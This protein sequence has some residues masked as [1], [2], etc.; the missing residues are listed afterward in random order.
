MENCFQSLTLK[1]TRKYPNVYRG[2]TVHS[3]LIVSDLTCPKI[4]F[5]IILRTKDVLGNDVNSTVCIII[6]SCKA[7][8]VAL[9][10][11]IIFTAHYSRRDLYLPRR[12]TNCIER[13]LRYDVYQETN[14]QPPQVSRTAH[15][16]GYFQLAQDP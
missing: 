5:C 14:S 7:S 12:V 15:I 1:K 13:T 2:L 8:G 9:A 11:N 3:K 6:R 4:S 16:I 10:H